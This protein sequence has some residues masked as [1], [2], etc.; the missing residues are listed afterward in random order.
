MPFEWDETKR[1]ENRRKHGIDF[2][3]CEAVFDGWTICLEDDRYP[4]QE[5]RF[6]T[7]GLLEGR[8]VVVAH[9][10]NLGVTRI[11]SIRRANRHEQ[12]LYFKNSPFPRIAN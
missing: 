12:A 6:L 8:V 5:M 1:L 11:I 10:E 3:R 9:S 7:V 4:Y 2:V